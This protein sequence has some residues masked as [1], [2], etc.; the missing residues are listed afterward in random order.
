MFDTFF[1][2]SDLVWVKLSTSVV[3]V[4]TDLR[5]RFDLRTP[6]ALQAACCLHL[7]PEAVMITGDAAF[8][9]IPSL[10]LAVVA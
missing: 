5:A 6:D 4:A 2:R 1:S 8:A 7:G 9:R 10:S 3:E